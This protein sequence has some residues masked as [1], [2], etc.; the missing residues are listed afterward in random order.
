MYFPFLLIILKTNES[1]RPLHS[2]YR[3]FDDVNANTSRSPNIIY[4]MVQLLYR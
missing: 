2:K 3:R 4:A 1:T